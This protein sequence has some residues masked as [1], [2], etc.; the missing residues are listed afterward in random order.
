MLAS[1]RRFITGA[2]ALGCA[3]L[4]PAARGALVSSH[5]A[6]LIAELPVDGQHR[7][8]IYQPIWAAE[9]SVLIARVQIE[10]TTP[11]AVPIGLGYYL[12]L[13]TGELLTEPMMH[14]II[15]G[16]HHKVITCIGMKSFQ[17]A[18]LA[19]VNFMAYAVCSEPNQ[20]PLSID[21]AQIDIATV[22]DA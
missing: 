6:N 17:Q 4:I 22:R 8:V 10:F 20:Q 14:N 1:R 5:A 13:G 15:Y 3:A 11:N 9:G 19:G 12:Q 21:Y 18:T 2:A 16:E 7:L